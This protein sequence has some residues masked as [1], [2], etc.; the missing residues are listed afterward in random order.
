MQPADFSV[1]LALRA[2]TLPGRASACLATGSEKKASCYGNGDCLLADFA[3]LFFAVSDGSERF[4]SASSSFLGRIGR[5]LTHEPAPQTQEQWLALANRAFA[6]QDYILSATFSAVAIEEKKGQKSAVIL[7]GGDS[8]IMVVDT[9]NKCVEFETEPDMNFA[10]RSPDLK[11]VFRIPLAPTNR[12]VILF[13]D[14]LCDVARLAGLDINSMVAQVASAFDVDEVPMRL[15]RFLKR[16]GSSAT[17]DDIAVIALDP[18]G[19]I[20][21]Q[22]GFLI[23][24]TSPGTET[25]FGQDLAAGIVPDTWMSL[26]QARAA[27][28]D[29]VRAGFVIF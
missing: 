9:K 21:R 1:N 27:G 26:E 18:A 13:S 29:P 3:N 25:A 24:G 17:H 7:S 20:P 12:R 4:P 15:S 6:R 16:K 5:Y 11:K 2:V 23:G 28:Y 8:R 22:Q 14:G 10:G 19:L